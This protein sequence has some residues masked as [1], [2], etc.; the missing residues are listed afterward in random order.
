[1]KLLTGVL[2]ALSLVLVGVTAAQADGPYEMV[3]VRPATTDGPPGIFRVNV[4]SGE[5]MGVWGWGTSATAYQA[6]AEA[7][8]LPGGQYHLRVVE[9]LDNKGGWEVLRFDA[10]SGRTWSLS[11]GGGNPFIWTEAVAPGG[12]TPAATLTPMAPK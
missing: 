6:V 7:A 1:M 12:P 5:V 2:T 9:S 3:V 10:Q 4:A 8:P 11:G